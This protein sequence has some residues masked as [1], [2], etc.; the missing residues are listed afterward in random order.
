VRVFAANEPLLITA[1]PRR[2]PVR[3][4]AHAP[5]AGL[6]VTALTPIGGPVGDTTPGAV[7]GAIIGDCPPPTAVSWGALSLPIVLPA[8]M[9]PRIAG[10][11]GDATGDACSPPRIVSCSPI[12][13]APPPAKNALSPSPLVI[14]PLVME[15][16]IA[17]C[18]W[19]W[20]ER[21]NMSTV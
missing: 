20:R 11:G 15:P 8:G 2:C 7:A 9:A 6:N 1:P 13:A 10:I 3:R 19:S 12:V 14:V 4:G 5:V 17:I 18:S 21:I 16:D